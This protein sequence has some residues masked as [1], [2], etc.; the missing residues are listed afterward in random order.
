MLSSPDSMSTFSNSNNNGFDDQTNTEDQVPIE[1]SKDLLDINLGIVAA[2]LVLVAPER[3]APHRDKIRWA[4]VIV[5]FSRSILAI[6]KSSYFE[7]PLKQ[8]TSSS[9]NQPQPIRDIELK[10]LVTSLSTLISRKKNGRFTSNQFLTFKVEL[11]GEKTGCPSKPEALKLESENKVFIS[12]L[13]DRNTHPTEPFFT[14]ID[15][16]CT[17]PDNRK[18]KYGTLTLLIY[19]LFPGT[20]LPS[21][22]KP[23]WLAVSCSSFQSRNPTSALISSVELVFLDNDDQSRFD[24]FF[25]QGQDFSFSQGF[26]LGAG[27]PNDALQEVV[28][29][30]R[31]FSDLHMAE[32]KFT[33]VLSLDPAAAKDVRNIAVPEGATVKL[34]DGKYMVLFSLSY[35]KLQQNVA[36]VFVITF[37]SLG[38]V[39]VMISAFENRHD[40]MLHA[41][42]SHCAVALCRI[43]AI[44]SALND[45]I[46]HQRQIIHM[47]DKWRE[48]LQS[49]N[50]ES[51]LPSDENLLL[52]N[53]QLHD[54]TNFCSAWM[55][56]HTFEE[57]ERI[58]AYLGRFAH[59][60]LGCSIEDLPDNWRISD[61]M[62]V[63]TSLPSTFT[64]AMR[65]GGTL[66]KATF[67]VLRQLTYKSGANC[68]IFFGL[69]YGIVELLEG[70][71]HV[72]ETIAG[73]LAK[74]K[75]VFSFI[76]N[77]E[78]QSKILFADII[79]SIRQTA[80]IG[81]Q[82]VCCY[83]KFSKYKLTRYVGKFILSDAI[84]TKIA[85][86][87]T[88]IDSDYQLLLLLELHR[89][90][91]KQDK[92]QQQQNEKLTLSHPFK[93]Q[94]TIQQSTLMNCDRDHPFQEAFAALQKD[95][96]AVYTKKFPQ[97][98]GNSM[99][100][101]DLEDLYINTRISKNIDYHSDPEDEAPTTF[102]AET[103]FGIFDHINPAVVTLL[104]SPSG[105]GKTT[106]CK[107]LCCSQR[108]DTFLC[109]FIPLG[110][111]VGKGP[112]DSVE[113]LLSAP[114]DFG[115]SLTGLSQDDV[116]LIVKHNIPVL[117]ILDGFDEVQNFLVEKTSDT[118]SLDFKRFI[119]NFL[120]P[121]SRSKHRANPTHPLV[122]RRDAVLIASR[123]VPT[124]IECCNFNPENAELL[125]NK[126]ALDIWNNEQMIEYCEKYFAH[127][128]FGKSKKTFAQL[129]SKQLILLL[130]S[131]T[132]SCAAPLP[133]LPLFV[134]IVCRGIV[135]RKI[136]QIP[137]VSFSNLL[138]HSIRGYFARNDRK[139]QL[140]RFLL[141]ESAKKTPPATKELRWYAAILQK[142]SD[143][144]VIHSLN[145]VDI[146]IIA[147]ECME[148][149]SEHTYFCLLSGTLHL[150]QPGNS[151]SSFPWINIMEELGLLIADHQNKSI[152]FVHPTFAEYFCAKFVA[153]DLKNSHFA[154]GAASSSSSSS[155]LLTIDQL[156]FKTAFR[157]TWMLL[158][159]IV[160]EDPN[161]KLRLS[162]VVSV[163]ANQECWK[164][165]N[166]PEDARRRLRDPKDRSVWGDLD[167]ASLP[168][169]LLT[170]FTTVL[171]DPSELLLILPSQIYLLPKMAR[172]C[173]EFGASNTGEL[174]LQV[175]NIS[176][177]EP[178][179]ETDQHADS[180]YPTKFFSTI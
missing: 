130:T 167:D 111:L 132:K 168:L 42:K 71:D 38:F 138:E 32:L 86:C 11:F 122:R 112:I 23:G 59:E 28:S 164:E 2:N 153:Y 101:V 9:T 92:T 58:N 134:N 173:G 151:D 125:L 110:E 24:E 119:A 63:E 144:E 16:Y 133:N 80:A 89:L 156:P 60:N 13:L 107:R 143:D 35:S 62:E 121:T 171:D 85:P 154:N 65:L 177:N 49:M 158:I 47:L 179:E 140:E 115:R 48:K 20:S 30:Y 161:A 159:N 97:E 78:N 148:S 8:S 102:T 57:C 106:L 74:L 120:D 18:V 123:Q 100:Q 152:H 77:L 150:C 4:K 176:T 98:I 73:F 104:E 118:S 34:E 114:N 53:N 94:Q 69:A 163:V 33:V 145:Q 17:L 146:D 137:T 172:L 6:L 26:R 124:D 160:K 103:V 82:I 162:D 43:E 14:T 113:Q 129:V 75:Q 36:N 25:D 142:F 91:K 40:F 46:T 54:I 93:Q 155:S 149:A 68:G 169:R 3:D 139:D 166:I 70:T 175:Y 61:I 99:K 37:S 81:F 131:V 21:F 22:D 109:V 88:R 96:R 27:A 29:G 117:F 39:N 95:L 72:D 64:T 76:R 55:N 178:P 135:D 51:S 128:P 174:I 108:S 52:W 31:H 90:S 7:V 66:A 84:V 1:M 56:L 87:R 10:P 180:V 41:L 170:E 105:S 15:L 165:E 127:E 12:D 83:E 5:E 126:W 67:T 50:A 116:K 44:R 79:Y 157:T 141:A 19:R 136:N 45:K 147:D